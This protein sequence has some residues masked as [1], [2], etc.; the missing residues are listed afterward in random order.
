MSTIKRT[1][2]LFP[3]PVQ[4][5]VNFIPQ[6]QDEGELT[7]F[8]FTNNLLKEQNKPDLTLKREPVSDATCIPVSIEEDSPTINE[9][10]SESITPSP[11]NTEDEEDT[12]GIILNCVL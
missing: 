2:N 5:N 3:F 4:P 6:R 7:P 1:D 9:A 8:N 11:M 12:T 10:S